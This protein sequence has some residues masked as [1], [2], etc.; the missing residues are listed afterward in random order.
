V[1]AR[2]GPLRALGNA[3]TP[4]S[5]CG[6]VP[7]AIDRLLAGL[8]H[9]AVVLVDDLDALEQ[10]SPAIGDRLVAVVSGSVEAR[11]PVVVAGAQTA[12]AATAYRGAL[13]ALR[14]V[15][16]GLILGP[17]EPGSGE[18]LGV[19]L[20]W[21]VDPGRPHAPGRGA[22]QNGRDVVAVQVLDPDLP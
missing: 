19:G 22:R 13:G 6:F 15:R 14:A 18:V 20:E 17:A 12:R 2:D 4:D 11:G 5:T 7:A 3:R 1:I 10:Q 8:S 9:A 21:V 16:H